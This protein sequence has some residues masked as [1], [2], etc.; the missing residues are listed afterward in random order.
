MEWQ[1]RGVAERLVLNKYQSASLHEFIREN[2]NATFVISARL[3]ESRKQRKYLHGALIPLIAFY[4]EGMSHKSSADLDRV[5]EWLKQEF[6]GDMVII[7]DK[8]VRIGMS[9]KGG[10]ALNEICEKVTDWLV[11]NYAP[12]ADAMNP[13]KYKYWRDAIYP[14][15]D[16]AENYI[17]YLV[18][19][20]VLSP[21][22]A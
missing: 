9:T 20:G 22:N 1:G 7:G 21:A 10:K 13:K 2:P 5:F 16:G 15:S 12:P 3:P 14:Y 11:D 6:N 8:P 4:Q 19:T 17:D 18:E